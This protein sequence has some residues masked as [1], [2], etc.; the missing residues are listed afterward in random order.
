MIKIVNIWIKVLKM[1]RDPVVKKKHVRKIMM[2]PIVTKKKM[3]TQDFLIF[4]ESEKDNGTIWILIQ[5]LPPPSKGRKDGN[6]KG[7]SIWNP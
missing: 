5:L 6:R 3:R 4:V 1:K 7:F 2:N